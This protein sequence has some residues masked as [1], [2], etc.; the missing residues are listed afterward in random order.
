MAKLP[1]GCILFHFGSLFSHKVIGAL[2]FKVSVGMLL[3]VY[4]DYSSHNS[5]GSF[6]VLKFT[7]IISII[8]RLKLSALPFNSGV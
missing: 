5:P 4:I 8:V 6:A 3:I 1:K 7:L 2:I